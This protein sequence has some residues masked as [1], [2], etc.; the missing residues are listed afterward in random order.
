MVRTINSYFY[1]IF[2]NLAPADWFEMM[3]EVYAT[4][5]EF[6]KKKKKMEEKQQQQRNAK[7]DKV[8]LSD[9][10]FENMDT[11]EEL[12]F[13]AD[14]TPRFHNNTKDIISAFGRSRATNFQSK[15][16]D[17]DPEEDGFWSKLS[18]KDIQKLED[19]QVFIIYMQI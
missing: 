18:D 4:H 17:Q 14:L 10:G 11:E 6:Q 15:P 7:N 19:N 8:D 16:L 1:K 5:P 3:K 12:H 13:E 2:I 9:S